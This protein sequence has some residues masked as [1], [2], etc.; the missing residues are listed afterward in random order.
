MDK[1]EQF[2]KTFFQECE[3][4]LGDLESHIAKLRQGNS[5][6]EPLHAAFRAIHT[7][8]GG[9]GM[10][11][12]RRLVAFAHLFETVLD[13]M[14][15]GRIAAGDAA[16]T[17]ILHAADVLSDLVQ[18]ARS[19]EGLPEHHDAES[20]E[21]LIRLAGTGHAPAVKQDI[22]AKSQ[23]PAGHGRYRI[24][25]RPKPQL[26]RS[27]NEP[28]LIVRQLQELGSLATT[29][30]LSRLPHFTDLDPTQAYLAWSFELDTEAD[31]TAIRQVFEF[32]ESDCDLTITTLD[33][34][35][36]AAVPSQS[37]PTATAAVRQNRR[38]ASI[39]VDLDRIDRLVNMVGEIAIVQAMISQQTDQRLT[40]SHPQLVQEVSQLLQL[41]QSLQDS[42]MAIR[43]VPVGSLFARMPRLVRELAAA[44][45]KRILLQTSGEDTE[46]DKTVIEELGDPLLHMVRNAADHG[47][48]R[49]AD[50][51][52]AGKPAEGTIRLSAGQR[53]GQIVIEIADDG[54]GLDRG[55]IRQKAVEQK[56]VSDGA[57]LSDEEIVNLI[58]QP[59][60]STAEKVTDISGRG[61]GM[62]VVKRNI[63]KL[64]GR[65]A[66]RS[67]EGRGSK[68]AITLPLTLAILP[69]MI[70]RAGRSDYVIPLPNIIECLQ[71]KPGQ[72]KSLPEHGEV[73]HFRNGY[74]PLVRLGAVFNIAGAGS[75]ADPLIIVVDDE[76]GNTLGLA[77]DEITGQQQVV[78][79]SLRENLDPIAGLAG[80][81][82]LGDG[83]VALILVLSEL[84]DLHRNRRF[85]WFPL[86]QGAGT[87]SEPARLIA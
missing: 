69:G 25:F 49:P 40:D 29:A 7:I 35:T 80:A 11:G 73:L 6:A 43:A 54:R 38:N 75:P 47:I 82:V 66:F 8:K 71:A 64:G 79:K 27:A 52:A 78:I 15:S 74:I 67:E 18:A 85:G 31:E 46:I 9:A 20:A 51:V 10:F 72:V 41:T 53:G 61:V 48:E 39:R 62:D 57:D 12:F 84:L 37:K 87:G 50:R 58:F 81:T 86:N 22:K 30:D 59:G 36:A 44:T 23:A 26:L 28:L 5:G 63:Q 19:G 1:I 42:V 76:N 83:Q 14:R 45:G 55:R 2:K 77:V 13:R 17:T 3:E 34:A 33:A 65:V 16:V 56:L 21:Q 70:V 24:E 60:F 32:V 68:M 4:L